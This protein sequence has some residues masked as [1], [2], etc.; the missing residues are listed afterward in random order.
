MLLWL[1]VENTLNRYSRYLNQ[2]TKGLT[3]ELY[4]Q[5]GY[6]MMDH[7][8]SLIKYWGSGTVILSPRDLNESQLVRLSNEILKLG[9]SV[10][11]DPQL[12][13]AVLTN[14]DR[15]IVH[16]FWPTSN[17]FPS[18]S[19]LS[20]CLTNL[21]EINKQIGAKQIILPGMIAKSVDADWLESQRQVIE[22]SQRHEIN[23]ISTIMT[24]ALSYD[25]VRNDDQVELLLESIPLWDVLSIY[26]VCEHPNGDYLVTDPGWLANVAD[27]VA[28][29]RLAGKQVIVGYCNHQ[30]L[31]VAGSAA[32]AIASGTWMNVRFFN[33]QK[34]ITQE[35]DEIKM[36]STWYYAPHLFSEYK[37]SFLDLAKK[38][39]VLDNL[40]T[41]ALYGSNYADELFTAP[42]PQLA[43]FTEQQAFRH[44]L[45]CLNYQAKN[46]VKKTFDETMDTYKKQLDHAQKELNTLHANGIKGQ[47]R[48][49]LECI[50]ANRGAAIAL[51][52]NRGAVLSRNW[53]KLIK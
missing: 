14:H 29:I 12:Y 15:L 20:K 33:E 51:S 47:K 36:R 8:R 31:L 52:K 27:I 50:D 48:D 7:C 21:I 30:M 1:H 40:Q 38:N 42:Q 37:I 23:D 2:S 16:S 25:A 13:N 44:Y 24:V 49:F 19:E 41:E 17:K 22:E 10:V 35:D 28:G 34:F 26:L 39:G 6:G 11:L 4:L 53:A 3:M 5:F 45:Q 9:G 43:S 46:S 18:G 32:T